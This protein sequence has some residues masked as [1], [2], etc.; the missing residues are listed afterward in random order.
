[1]TQKTPLEKD[2]E[3]HELVKIPPFPLF[4]IAVI[5][6]ALGVISIYS[7]NLR[8]ELLLVRQE[9]AVMKSGFDK[10]TAELLNRISMLEEENDACRKNTEHEAGSVFSGPGAETP[11]D[12]MRTAP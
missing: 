4:L 7:Y 11:R 10:K 8:H 6:I 3:R 12:N 5:S 9:T 2:I 1:M